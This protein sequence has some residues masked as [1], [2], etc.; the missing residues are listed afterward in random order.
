MLFSFFSV[1]VAGRSFPV[2]V[3]HQN[4]TIK[5]LTKTINEQPRTIVFCARMLLML[6]ESVADENAYF[7][8]R[9]TTTGDP[10]PLEFT[11]L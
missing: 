11:M 2:A 1:V 7:F 10:T 6:L 5:R 4:R 3:D 8:F 9:T